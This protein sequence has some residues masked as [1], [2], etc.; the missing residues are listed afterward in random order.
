MEYSNDQEVYDEQLIKIFATNRMNE[1]K[2]QM[3]RIGRMRHEGY[4]M[5][6]CNDKK[7]DLSPLMPVPIINFNALNEDN[8]TKRHMHKDIQDIYTEYK[9]QDQLSGIERRLICVLTIQDIWAE[10]L[11][12]RP[13]NISLTDKI[14]MAKWVKDV[15]EKKQNSFTEQI[16]VQAYFPRYTLGNNHPY[17]RISDN[18]LFEK[19]IGWNKNS[20]GDRIKHLYPKEV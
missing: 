9:R 16:L 20:H 3:K 2:D 1:I 18:V 5:Y 12:P 13:N 8:N 11:P 10:S 15:R 6:Y 17:A 14:A 4:F 19:E 7:A